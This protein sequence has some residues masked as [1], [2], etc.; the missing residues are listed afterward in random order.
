MVPNGPSSEILIRHQPAKPSD[1]E[2]P[3]YPALPV[4]KKCAEKMEGHSDGKSSRSSSRPFSHFPMQF[5]EKM[6]NPSTHLAHKMNSRNLFAQRFGRPFVD[7]TN[8]RGKFSC[9]QENESNAVPGDLGL[10][11]AAEEHAYNAIREPSVR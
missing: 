2:F 3:R 4:C 10:F 11:F 9:P 8:R 6:A 7:Q 1:Y 5:P